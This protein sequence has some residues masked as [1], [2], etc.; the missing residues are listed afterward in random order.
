MLKIWKRNRDPFAKQLFF[1]LLSKFKN[2]E[3]H[4]L[5]TSFE[6]IFKKK[7]NQI[8]VLDYEKYG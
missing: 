2:N 5:E 7:G 1:L 8:V 6:N 4:I 3:K